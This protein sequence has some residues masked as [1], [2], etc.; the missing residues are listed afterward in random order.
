MV[1]SP[2]LTMLTILTMLQPLEGKIGTE[3]K[4]QIFPR[5]GYSIVSIVIIVRFF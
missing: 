5:A 2:G 3:H 1:R 4:S